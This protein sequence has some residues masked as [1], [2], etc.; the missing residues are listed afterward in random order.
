MEPVVT[1]HVASRQFQFYN[2]AVILFMGCAS[3][4]MGY[5]ASIIGTT[6]G[7]CLPYSTVSEIIPVRLTHMDSSTDFYRIL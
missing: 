4:A 2:V 1:E 5:S 6:L 7:R 3:V